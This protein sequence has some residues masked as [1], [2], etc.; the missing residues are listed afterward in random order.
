L[1]VE[2]ILALKLHI[3]PVHLEVMDFTE[4]KYLNDELAKYQAGS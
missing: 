2:F 3:S 4:V 1:Q